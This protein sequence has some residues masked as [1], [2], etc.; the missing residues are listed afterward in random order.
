MRTIISGGRPT[1]PGL[2]GRCCLASSGPTSRSAA[3]TRSRNSSTISPEA[4]V[5]KSVYVQANWPPLRAEAE[6]A[7]VQQTADETGWPHAIVGYADM[8]AEDVR[9]ALDRLMRYPLMPRRPHATALARESSNI[10]SHCALTSATTRPC[11][12]ISG[13]RRTTGS[14]RSAGLRAADGRAPR[15]SPRTRSGGHL[16]PTARRDAGGR[17]GTGSGGL[18]RGHEARWRRSR[19]SYANFP[20]SAPSSTATI[21]PTSP[22]RPRAVGLFGP[23]RC[24]FGSNFPIEKLWTDYARSSMPTVWRLPDLG[25]G[26]A[27]GPA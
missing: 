17:F 15:G 25:G 10:A 16:H 21:R 13:A 7:W 18:A 23:Q 2:P 11:G 14:L 24:L 12:G 5:V 6:V 8:L 19:T 27:R 22:D 26:A 20:A 9:P 4:S 1:C 3:I